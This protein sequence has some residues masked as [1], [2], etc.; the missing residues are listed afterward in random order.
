MKDNLIIIMQ[1]LFIITMIVFITKSIKYSLEYWI[2][3]QIDNAE[4]ICADS[5]DF[6]RCL[7]NV[8][9]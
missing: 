5:A 6:D 1:V 3:R 8:L 9:F 2:E 7:D 4:I